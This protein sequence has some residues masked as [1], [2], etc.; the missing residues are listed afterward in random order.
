MMHSKD[1]LALRQWL[2]ISNINDSEITSHRHKAMVA[3]QSLYDYCATLNDPRVRE[4]F[5]ALERLQAAKD[6]YDEFSKALREFPNLLILPELFPEVGLTIDEITQRPRS[7]G[8]V[9]QFIYE[10]F[11]LIDPESDVPED[12]KVLVTT[13]HSAKGLEAE[14][15]F[16]TWMNK[17]YM[18]MPKR[19]LR[20]E[21]RLLYVALTRAKQDVILTFHETYD[22]KRRCP[23]KQEVMSPFLREIKEH[24]NVKRVTAD[25]VR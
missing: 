22:D 23:L 5:S 24:L 12:E 15:V 3:D 10:K 18:P 13:L 2:S 4:I 11:G 17:K 1:S 9:I 20:E 16:V 7:V 21:R 14:Y 8:A 25:D 6:D 19:D